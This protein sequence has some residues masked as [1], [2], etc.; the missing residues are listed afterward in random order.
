MF[1]FLSASFLFT[2]CAFLGAMV[3]TAAG[4]DPWA[5]ALVVTGASYVLPHVGLSAG[6]LR[7]SVPMS[8]RV[9]PNDTDRAIWNELQ[10]QYGQDANGKPN[11][12]IITPSY[13][14]VAVPLAASLNRV[15]FPIAQN[16]GAA[17]LVDRRLALNDA[18]VATRA[19]VMYGFLDEAATD[20]GRLEFLTFPNTARFT[21]AVAPDF[22]AFW[23]GELFIRVNDRVFVEG[24]DGRAF[25]FSGSAQQGV[26]VSTGATAPA[27]VDSAWNQDQAFKTMVP[28]INFN[29]SSKNTV[30]YGWQGTAYN[31][32][33]EAGTGYAVFYAR[34][35][36]MQNGS[37]W[38]NA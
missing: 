14:R 28:T 10:R 26:E 36:L 18:F 33:P 17:S 32:R 34:G 8:Q 27:Y 15:T 37:K 12:V 9:F 19:S 3:A 7:M 16:E 35:F 30:Q 29:G 24:L 20:D 1:R 31:F 23:N 11:G 38:V 13:L 2:V 21:P 25:Q 22:R 6:T 4:F 5:G